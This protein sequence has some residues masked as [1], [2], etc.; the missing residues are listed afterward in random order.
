MADSTSRPPVKRHYHAAL[1]NAF[2]SNPRTADAARVAGVS[3]RTAE[4]WKSR[5][6]AEVEAHRAELVQEVLTR[7]RG[8]LPAIADE[9]G[10]IAT[11]SE[12][13]AYTRVAAAKAA[14]EAFRGLDQHSGLEA[15]MAALESRL[16]HP[17]VRAALARVRPARAEPLRPVPGPEPEGEA[18]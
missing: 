10:G 5:Y 6:R 4:R 17:E 7:L 9:L 15:R 11:D 18:A 13:P 3:V 14:F 12:Q 8:R 16:D 1:L 2:L